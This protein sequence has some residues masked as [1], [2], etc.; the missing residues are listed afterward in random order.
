MNAGAEALVLFAHGARDPRWAQ[1]VDALAL[2]VAARVPGLPVR[3]AFLEFM[4]PDLATA[5][6]ALV[7]DGATR[8]R[9]APVFLAA[10]GHVLRDLPA[11]ADACRARH[12]GVSIDLLPVLGALPAVLDAMAAACI[13]A[14][15]DAPGPGVAPT[16]DPTRPT[17]G[18]DVP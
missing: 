1:T 2:R 10:G 17:P 4:A 12:P 6:D 8:V 16:P 14:A 11:L 15:A 3:C 5:I 13:G 7:A 9:V 18:V